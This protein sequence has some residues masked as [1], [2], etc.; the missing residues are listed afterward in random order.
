MRDFQKIYGCIL[1]LR[2][3]LTDYSVS[4]FAIS[5]GS[6]AK[7]SRSSSVT[8]C[9]RCRAQECSAALGISSTSSVPYSQSPAKGCPMAD[10]CSRS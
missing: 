5:S 6:G 8:G 2:A 3:V 9:R 4:N 10:I 7:R 1:T